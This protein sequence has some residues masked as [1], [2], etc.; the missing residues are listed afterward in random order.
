MAVCTIEKANV[1][2]NKLVQEGRLGKHMQRTR[3]TH[4]AVSCESLPMFSGRAACDVS[5][6]ASDSASLSCNCLS[7]TLAYAC[8]ACFQQ[9][10]QLWDMTADWL[11]CVG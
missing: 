9:V 6:K 3:Q 7:C 8:L 2:I 4:H 1:A 11:T 5:R 10:I